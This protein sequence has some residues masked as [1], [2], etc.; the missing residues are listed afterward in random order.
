MKINHISVSRKDTW[1]LC[2]AKYKFKYH[3]GLKSPEEEPFYF[4]YGKI[5]HAIAEEYVKARGKKKLQDVCG[6]VLSGKILIENYEG[7]G[8]KAPALPRNYQERLKLHLRAI[9]KL[10]D[11]VGF[12]GELEYPFEYDLDPPN[13]RNIVGFIDRLIQKDDKFFIIDY[14]TTQ[15]GKYR[16]TEKTI[17]EDLQLRCYSRVIQKKFDVPAKSIRAALYYLEEGKLLGSQFSESS[18]AAAEKDL[19]DTYRQ[20][21]SADPDK[22]WGTIGNHCDRCEFKS[23]CPFVNS[24]AA[25]QKRMSGKLPI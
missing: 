23:M 24:S 17:K 5:A 2:K 18:L 25:L 11:Q 15:K 12:D 16:K 7:E 10:T 19:L 8:Q 9:Q 21:E 20:I 3:L 4:T 22:T 14:K 13:G 6:D 1:D